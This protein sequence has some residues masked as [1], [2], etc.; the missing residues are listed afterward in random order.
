MAISYSFAGARQARALMRDIAEFVEPPDE[1]SSLVDAFDELAQASAVTDP[2]TEL[3]HAVAAGKLR[4]KALDEQIAKAVS[5]IHIQEFRVGLK[6]RVEPALVKQFVQALNDGAADAVIT[7]LSP[8]FDTAASALQ[9]CGKLVQ[10]GVDP[11]TF[12]AAADAK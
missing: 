11:E 12:L 7:S 4:G 5:A 2:T 3:V 1:L 6:A 9:E 8:A 10:P